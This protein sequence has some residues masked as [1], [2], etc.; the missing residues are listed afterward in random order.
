MKKII[1]KHPFIKL[2]LAFL[3]AGMFYTCAYAQDTQE[4]SPFSDVAPGDANFV[5]INYLKENGLVTGYDDGTFRPLQ[6]VNRAEALKM[7]F[8]ALKGPQ[9]K[10]PAAFSFKDVRKNDWYYQ[11][12]LD[13]WNNFLVTGYPDGLFHPEKTINLAESLKIIL[14]QDGDTI[15]ASVSNPPYSDVTVTSWFA[16]YAQVAK[17]LTLVQ[18]S[19]CDGS[20][21][22]S[23][24]MSRGNFAELLY[25]VIQSRRNTQ[26]GRAT[27]YADS[28]AQESTASRELY[29]P[30]NLTAAHKTLPFNTRL[31]VTNLANGKSVEV[32]VND[33]GPYATGVDLD[34]SKSAFADIASVG[35]GIINIEYK[36]LTDG[37]TNPNT[38]V[39]GF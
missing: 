28:L 7:L 3:L 21:N 9:T 27:W 39:Y 26:F 33:R 25:R 24:N 38:V 30:T 29:I 37:Q 17:Q 22:P 1:I 31:L 11:Y 16:P 20:L 19:R 15:P 6:E 10:N 2:C 4:T 12:L 32:R 23:K 14:K 8:L 36:V 34:L 13:A 35:A 5:S 18:E